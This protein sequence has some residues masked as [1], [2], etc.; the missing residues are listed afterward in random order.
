MP[1][2]VVHPPLASRLQAA[3]GLQAASA[4]HQ[5]LRAA[6]SRHSYRRYLERALGVERGLDVMLT[7]FTF[8]WDVTS[9]SKLL[10]LSGDLLAL[11]ASVEEI[12]ALPTCTAM[13]HV[14]DPLEAHCWLFVVERVST[15]HWAAFH[16]LDTVTRELAA[17]YLRT[18][19]SR[20]GWDQVCGAFDR[21]SA[22]DQVLDQLIATGD[23]AMRGHYSW[24]A[25]EQGGDNI[26]FDRPERAH[27]QSVAQRAIRVA[28][29]S[30]NLSFPLEPEAVHIVPATTKRIED[31]SDVAAST[32]ESQSE[33]NAAIIPPDDVAD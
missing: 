6:R 16:E 17:S 3:L 19:L 2:T 23:K 33:R 9:R 29:G 28:R 5:I 26:L 22:D 14:R 4:D 21:F 24:F 15:A 18:L 1:S 20:R 31:S 13:Q 30:D 8:D 25:E 7:N 11:G 12:L 10:L 27:G 32:V